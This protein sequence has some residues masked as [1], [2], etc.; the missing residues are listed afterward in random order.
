MNKIIIVSNR[1]PLQISIEDD[2]LQVRPSV[3]GLATGLKSVHKESN[4]IWIGW[5][6][7]TQEELT[8]ELEAKVEKAVHKEQ[9]VTVSL[10]QSDLDLYYYGFS[11]RTLWPLFHYFI[12]YTEYDPESWNAYKR[13]N[14]KFAEVVLKHAEDGDQIWIQ[15]Y[16]LLLVPAL[17]KAKK[18]TFLS[19]SSIIFLFLPMKYSEPFLSVE[20]F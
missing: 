1:L 19:D 6:G 2:H 4:G 13:V 11:N 3:G 18:P 8:P 20:N 15:D 12:E 16:Q 7:L 9:C 17:V 14:E 5:S 10:T